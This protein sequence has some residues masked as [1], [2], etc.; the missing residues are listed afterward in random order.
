MP[1]GG[2]HIKIEHLLYETLFSSKV[3]R[4]GF[5]ESKATHTLPDVDR[6][7]L[8][9]I[10]YDLVISRARNLALPDYFHLLN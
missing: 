6:L 10:Y 8:F 3:L 7:F 9:V 4:N 1:T 2:W 5:V